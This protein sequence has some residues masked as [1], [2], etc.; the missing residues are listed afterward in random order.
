MTEFANKIAY[1]VDPKFPKL[2]LE[3]MTEQAKDLTYTRSLVSS[4]PIEK[5]TR[6]SSQCWL[7]WD[8]WIAGIM[9][10][11]FVSANNDYY[12]YELNHFDSGIQV[13]KYESSQYYGWHVDQIETPNGLAR[14]LSMSLVLDTDFEGGELEIYNP[15][16]NK[17]NRFDLQPGQVC[18]FPSWASHQVT[19]VTSGTRY[20]LVAWMNGPEFR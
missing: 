9:H 8:S 17:A 14:K 20:S 15:Y 7:P 5:S 12:H 1:V 6:T 13:T 11:L 18:I 16:S 19:P 2:I 3:E 10:N 4:D